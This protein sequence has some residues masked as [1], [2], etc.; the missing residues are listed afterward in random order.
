[1]GSRHS[2]WRISSGIYS[3][4]PPHSQHLCFFRVH[5]GRC[6][7][8]VVLYH[9][10][11]PPAHSCVDG[12]LKHYTRPLHIPFDVPEQTGTTEGVL[13]QLPRSSKPVE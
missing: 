2:T 7:I 9:S 5:A 1:M 6:S 10:T 3:T 13:R 12:L 11:V 8:R 4:E